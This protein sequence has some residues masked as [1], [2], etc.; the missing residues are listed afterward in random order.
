MLKPKQRKK[1]CADQDYYAYKISK[2]W[3]IH[4]KVQML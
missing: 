4:K 2:S 1:S 3:K